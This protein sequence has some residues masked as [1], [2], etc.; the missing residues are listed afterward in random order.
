VLDAYADAASVQE[1]LRE[2]HLTLRGELPGVVRVAVALYDRRTDVIKTFVHSTEGAAQPFLHYEARLHDVPSLAELAAH[3]QPRVLDDFAA[4]GGAL[5]GRHT[6]VLLDCGYR[7]SFTLPIIDQGKLFGFLFFDAAAANFFT[8]AAVQHLAI[9]GRLISLLII[10]ALTPANTLRSLV[11]V[12]KA[13]SH[14]RNGE[15]GLH[16]ERMARYARLIAR[17]LADRSGD[18]AIDDEFV[19]FVF[20]F[21][22]LHDVGK[23]GIPDSILLKPGRLDEAEFAV[24]KTHVTKGVALIEKI[25]Q[26]F[27]VGRPQHIDVLR[28]IVHF[29]HEACDG[30]GYAEGLKGDA[31]PLEARVVA[32]ADVFDALTSK[33]SYKPAWSSAAALAYLNRH[34]GIIFDPLC[35]AALAENKEAVAALQRQFRSDDDSPEGFHEAYT[36]DI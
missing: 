34:A 18:N 9:Y 17:T 21:A 23:I 32:V 36:L 2:I 19:E 27:G 12:T 33:R 29:H 7:S 14:L 28:N 4:H 24:M 6:E 13:L 20:R 31:I 1:Q 8:S 22:P 30:S 25:A 35:V 11:E 26:S 10:N 16:L 5:C 3:G 15:T